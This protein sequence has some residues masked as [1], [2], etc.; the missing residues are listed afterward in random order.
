[1]T[2]IPRKRRSTRLAERLTPCFCCGHAISQRHHLLP[3][4]R[5]GE[6]GST[7]N[8]CANCHEAYHILEQGW[9]DIRAKRR[10][11]RAMRIYA[12]LW[13][14]FGGRENPILDAICCLVEQS[15]T[16]QQHSVAGTDIFDLFTRLFGPEVGDSLKDNETVIRRGDTV[17]LTN[18]KIVRVVS[19]KGGYIHTT[20]GT[21]GVW[22]VEKVAK[23]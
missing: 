1:M 10:S 16:L 5:F 3:A 17:R 2:T 12:A 4:A 23:A 9:I 14:G 6:E 11:T 19:T 20:E 8:L 18:D 7:V 13:Q 22:Q 15:E 21:Y